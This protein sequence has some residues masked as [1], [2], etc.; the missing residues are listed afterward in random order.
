LPNTVRWIST[1]LLPFKNP[2]TNAMLYL[3]GTL[4][5]HE[6]LWVVSRKYPPTIF[7]LH[8]SS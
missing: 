1:A 5:K 3:G 8:L 4:R 2:I 7:S 6:E